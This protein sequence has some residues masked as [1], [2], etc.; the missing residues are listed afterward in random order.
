MSA[1][2]DGEAVAIDQFRDLTSGVA[3]PSILILDKVAKNECVETA[4]LEPLV[5]THLRNLNV[6]RSDR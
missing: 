1:A 5:R 6:F 2:L 3:G 4:D